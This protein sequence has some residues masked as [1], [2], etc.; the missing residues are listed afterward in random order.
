[1]ER[2]IEPFKVKVVEP[3]RAIT[4]EERVAAIARAGNNLFKLRA[5]E[6][7]IDLLTDS[8]T[9]AMSDN[10]WAGI[11]LGDEAYAGSRNYFNFEQAVHDI[12]GLEHVIPVHQGR[13]AENL[14]FSTVLGKGMVVPNNS[15]FDTTRANVEYHD[16]EALDLL[17][18]EGRDPH[19]VAPFKGNMDV[20]AL[21]R[22]I[23]EKGTERIPL[24]ML[25][26]TNNSGGGQP[27]SMANIKAVSAVCRA[28]KLPLFFDACRFAENAYF[29]KSR[30]EGY[31][32]RSV[33][34]IVAEMFSQVDGC[35][36]SAKKDGM[37]NMGGFLAMRDGE[38]A[39]RIRNLLILV[40]GFPTYGGLSG[41]DL[42][43]IARGLREVLDERYLQFRLGQV[44]NLAEQLEE[45]G[46]PI[47]RP[48]GGH[49]VY[50]NAGEFLPHIPPT[51]FPGQSLAVNLY[52]ESGVR[53]VEIGT[54]MFGGKDPA[55]GAE[56]TA[57]LELVRLAIP[58]R[59]YTTMHMNY[60]AQ[61]LLDLYEKREELEG[62]KIV[63][64]PPFLRHFSATLD[65]I[66]QKSVSAV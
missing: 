20:A 18:P 36:M 14:L 17:C 55:T 47:L 53:G 64:A 54:L 52:I 11:M 8:G 56:R 25:T 30:E 1:M 50:V 13:V 9:S 34:E 58:R 31:A 59:V 33:P 37:V 45:G 57:R 66:E 19:L 2:Y 61:A 27:V 43:A 42:E 16:A 26:V 10:Q 22:L 5:D 60:V 12:F 6:I 15:H 62:M 48:A 23:A 51:A 3:I 38:L 21:E 49:A 63:K 39:D 7:Y 35:T 28:H 41:R 65:F 44:A 29:I 46:V 40:E 24:V 4:R 32:E